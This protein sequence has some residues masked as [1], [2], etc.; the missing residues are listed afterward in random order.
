[1]NYL[2]RSTAAIVGVGAIGCVTSELMTRA[3]VGKL[4]I[5]DRDIVEESNLQRQTLFTSADIGKAKAAAAKEALEKINPE[6]R[7]EA[8]IDDLDRNNVRI[9]KAD[10]VLDCTDNMET[11]FLINDY[12]SSN[13]I[14]WVYSA[15][16]R[17]TGSVMAFTPMEGKP[18]FRCIFKDAAQLETCD[19]MGVSNT[20]TAA[21]AAIQVSEGIKVLLGKEAEKKMIRLDIW[22]NELEKL[23]A[24]KKSNC[25]ACSGNYEYLEGKKG[26][27]IVKL[28]GTNSYQIKG[29]KIDLRLLKQGLE[30]SAGTHVKDFGN[31]I[32]IGDAT[33]FSDGRALVKAADEK[34][35]RA[36]YSRLVG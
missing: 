2:R 32:N 4:I 24:K 23:S 22:K 29:K 35:A 17:T 34:Q 21:T 36:K 33:I 26:S 3:G 13:R 27:K 5:I 11:R 25:P 9:L 14:P 20:I 10:I 18:C 1:M 6:T 12:C 15:A 28:C 30:K 31:C 8:H 16:I 7:I 19:I